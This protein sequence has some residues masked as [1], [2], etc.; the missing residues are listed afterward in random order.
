MISRATYRPGMLVETLI[1][2]LGAVVAFLS[3]AATLLAL[4]PFLVALLLVLIPLMAVEAAFAVASST[5]R[6]SL[7][8]TYSAGSIWR[9]KVSMPP[10]NAISACRTPASCTRSTRCWGGDT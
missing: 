2:M 8:R 10:G 3:I 9:K 7:P 6:R 5:Y 4:A 1:G